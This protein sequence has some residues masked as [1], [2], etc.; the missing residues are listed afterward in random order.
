MTATLLVRE[1]PEEPRPG[2]FPGYTL[3][4][5][6]GVAGV[7]H[8]VQVDAEGNALFGDEG[9]RE[10]PNCADGFTYTLQ[11]RRLT[12]SRYECGTGGPAPLF[13]EIRSLTSRDRLR[14]LAADV[15]AFRGLRVKYWLL[16][17]IEA[18]ARVTP[19]GRV[20]VDRSDAPVRR[21]ELEPRTLDAYRLLYAKPL[22][23]PKQATGFDCI[24]EQVPT[25]KI[26]PTGRPTTTASVCRVDDVRWLAR[27]QLLR[28]EIYHG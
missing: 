17:D 8:T 28:N 15:P 6:G 9:N 19:A 2:P 26:T 24:P 1:P 21:G 20:M 16:D 25:Y 4:T 13:D 10:D 27:L 18:T 14:P 22:S 5:T 7:R 12:V 11:V 3:T 23:P